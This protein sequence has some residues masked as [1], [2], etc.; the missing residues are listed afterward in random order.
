MS[1]LAAGKQ[2]EAFCYKRDRYKRLICTVYVN[3]QDVA[4]SQLDAGL[5]WVYWRHVG[6]LPPDLQQA[7]FSAEDRAAAD[8][9]GLWRDP[10]SMP[11]W[12][13]CSAKAQS[14]RS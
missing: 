8:R 2:A 10:N 3:G 11:L 12:D 1:A 9:T 5:A 4:I 6:E 14:D 7:Y 13:W